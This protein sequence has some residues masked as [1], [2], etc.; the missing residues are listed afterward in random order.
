MGTKLI[1]LVEFL[2]S[3][4]AGPYIVTFDA[5]FKD[6]QTYRMVCESGVFTKQGMAS[7][8]NIPEDR[9]LSVHHYDAGRVIKFNLI[10]EISSGDFGD[11]TVFG[12]QLWTPLISLEIPVTRQGVIWGTGGPT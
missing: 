12:S 2:F 7:L 5:V 4:N 3:K 1:D 8:F 11:R 6:D 9:I 10:R